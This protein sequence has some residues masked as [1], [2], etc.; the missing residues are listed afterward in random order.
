VAGRWIARDPIGEI[1][2]VNSYEILSNNVVGRFDVLG[3][4]EYPPSYPGYDPDPEIDAINMILQ[5][6]LNKILF[7]TQ[8]RYYT[9]SK[10][11]DLMMSKLKSFQFPEKC[12]QYKNQMYYE[13]LRTKFNVDE[14]IKSFQQ[15]KVTG[16]RATDT[17]DN[18]GRATIRIP[19]YMIIGSQLDPD[20]SGKGKNA[21]GKYTGI[22]EIN[23]KDLLEAIS[24]GDF[25]NIIDT[26]MHE[27]SHIGAK[28]IDGSDFGVPNNAHD[29][30]RLARSTSGYVEFLHITIN[31]TLK[32]ECQCREFLWW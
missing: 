30:E 29:F 26:V 16:M 28:T 4:F 18:S 7:N 3:M 6:A 19:W 31:N 8:V 2:G 9:A 27:L 5:Q 17:G 12:Q 22:I 13:L 21:N 24:D 1:G 10:E 32:K 20:Q 25:S 11:I 15:G 23:R 14:S